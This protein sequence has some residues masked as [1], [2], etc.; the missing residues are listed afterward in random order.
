MASGIHYS[1]SKTAR[2]AG[3]WLAFLALAI[4]ILLPFLV[5]YE[6]GLASTPANAETITICHMPGATAALEPGADKDTHHA[7]LCEGCPICTALAAGHAFTAAGPVALPLP[8][9]AAIV[10]HL[11]MQMP[12]AFA[13]AAASYNPRAP[14]AIA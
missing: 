11:T 7:R 2:P 1:R 13:S 10:L 14:P 12:R 3:A 6:I 4:Q 8:Q 5:A 9:A